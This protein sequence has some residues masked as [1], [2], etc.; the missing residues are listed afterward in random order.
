MSLA[1]LL[2]I[3]DR[4][5]D[6]LRLVTGRFGFCSAQPTFFD[7]FY[8]TFLQ[9][10]SDIRQL[11]ENTDA[12]EQKESL[13]AGVSWLLREA[14]QS[15]NAKSWSSNFSPA[16]AAQFSVP[17]AYCDLWLSSLLRA[18]QKHDPLYDAS[19]ERAWRNVL[20]RCLESNQKPL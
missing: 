3:F 2:P 17:P 19:H 20:R 13:R 14:I 4:D 16:K 1:P 15:A 5:A 7:D 10:S 8:N 11:F 9:Q 6:A 18:V 12:A